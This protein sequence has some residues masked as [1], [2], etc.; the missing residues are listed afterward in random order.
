[1]VG[2][3]IWSATFAFSVDCHHF[4]AALPFPID[5]RFTFWVM[6]LLR[7]AVAYLSWDAYKAGHDEVEVSDDEERGLG[8][9]RCDERHLPNL[10]PGRRDMA[11]AA[12]A[13]TH[14]AH[15]FSGYKGEPG[16]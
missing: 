10:R 8:K 9:E 7:L 12:A 13:E 6:A 1:M 16:F 11:G 2:P 15:G 5:F 14:G 3:A 4:P